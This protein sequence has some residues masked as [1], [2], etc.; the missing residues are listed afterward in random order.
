MDYS[1]HVAYSDDTSY[2][3]L[4]ALYHYADFGQWRQLCWWLFIVLVT[5]EAKQTS[6]WTSCLWSR[7]A[8]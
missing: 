1:A 3:E 2:G 4:T 8:L 6:N 7:C 5:E